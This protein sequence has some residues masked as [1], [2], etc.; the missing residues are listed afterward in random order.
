MQDR[1]DIVQVI[2]RVPIEIR[3]KL[4]T[5]ASYQG[6]TMEGLMAEL[7]EREWKESKLEGTD[8]TRKES[9]ASKF[10]KN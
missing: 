6:K 3:T 5:L 2:M 4:K 8:G 10:T 7:I 9:S 1:V